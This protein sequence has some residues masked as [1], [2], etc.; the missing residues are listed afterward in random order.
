MV[1]R[2]RGGCGGVEGKEV[3]GGEVLGRERVTGVGEVGSGGW[4]EVEE[5]V[6]GGEETGGGG[7]VMRGVGG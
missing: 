2:G 5:G 3:E 7:G 1:E 6:L 4:G